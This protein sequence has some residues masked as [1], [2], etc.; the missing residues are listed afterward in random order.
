MSKVSDE[1]ITIGITGGI[2]CGKTNITNLLRK[3]GF[4]VIDSDAISRKLCEPGQSLFL[5]I[6]EEFGQGYFQNGMLNRDKLGRFIFENKEA[7]LKLNEISH[8][9]IVE[10]MKKQIKKCKDPILFL[11]I[12]LLFEAHLEYLCDK[13]ICVFLPYEIQLKRLMERDGISESF[14]RQKIASQMDLVE[15]RKKSNYTISTIGSFTETERLLD[16][17]ILNLKGDIKHV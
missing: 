7:R 4:T 5:A 13:I 2:A 17:L 8:P 15:K 11:D 1:M 6:A 16:Q 12:P 10:E 9:L 3:K 14:A